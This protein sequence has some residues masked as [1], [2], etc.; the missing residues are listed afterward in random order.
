[1]ARITERTAMR[2]AEVTT[3]SGGARVAI[4][5]T[6]TVIQSQLNEPATDSQNDLFINGPVYAEDKSKEC[7]TFSHTFSTSICCSFELRVV[8]RR[9]F[10]PPIHPCTFSSTP[11]PRPQLKPNSTSLR[12]RA[13]RAGSARSLHIPG[14]PKARGVCAKR[15]RSRALGKSMRPS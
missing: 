4:R 1:M 9:D 5:R 6:L 12:Q 2:I 8:L 7:Q 11:V 14:H 15:A 13:A 3:S 10:R